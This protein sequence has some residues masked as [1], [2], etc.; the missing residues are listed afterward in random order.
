MSHQ[1]IRQALDGDDGRCFRVC[2]TCE[3]NLI[4]TEAYESTTYDA[5]CPNPD[6]DGGRVW[7]RERVERAVS[8]VTSL[9]SRT[10]GHI[11]L[12]EETYRHE[13][14][15]GDW[16]TP[17]WFWDHRQNQPW[18][19]ALEQHVEEYVEPFEYT[20][21]SLKDDLRSAGHI[22]HFGTAFDRN[23]VGPHHSAWIAGQSEYFFADT[24][25]AAL[26]AA[27]EAAIS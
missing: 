3:G 20:I 1:K 9:I 14:E 22:A 10:E 25:F 6:C 11:T 26:L 24:E 23:T 4:V 18:Q 13:Q 5:D 21:K 15:Y 27:V 19:A 7:N 16:V 8:F 17:Q 12:A 2:E